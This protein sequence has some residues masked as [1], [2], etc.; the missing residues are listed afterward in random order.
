MSTCLRHGKC[1]CE[2]CAFLSLSLS[3][4][5]RER[6]VIFGLIAFLSVEEGC[7]AKNAFAYMT[8][9]ERKRARTWSEREQVT[10][11]GLKYRNVVYVPR[12][13]N[14]SN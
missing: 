12:S 14:A 4:L 5:W 2:W 1:V 7:Y 6:E 11:F 8:Q 9:T 3:V 13:A 10:F